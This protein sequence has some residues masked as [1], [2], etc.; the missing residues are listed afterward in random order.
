VLERTRKRIE[1]GE[2]VRIVLYGDSISEIGRT[3]GFFG[4]AKSAEMNWGEQLGRMLRQ[5]LP[6]NEF[7]IIHF[8]IG[9]QNSY[10]ALGR[11]D[12]LPQPA[13]L[14]LIELGTNDCGYHPLPSDVTAFAVTAL[15]DGLRVRHQAD[16]AIIGMGGDNPKSPKLTHADQTNALLQLTAR[17]RS[18]PFAD[19]RS[20]IL[21]AT[22]GGERWTDYHNG[23][24]DCHPN[25]AGHGIWAKVA[26]DSL[27]P[28]LSA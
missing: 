23:E 10:E 13:D 28:H 12:W 3:P 8:A 14:V 24:S 18:C 2:K 20:A 11:L 27:I 7:E 22:A 21:T 1:Q 6:R 4:G 17:L 26:F 16:V 9:G 5:R 19:V 15:I 25:D